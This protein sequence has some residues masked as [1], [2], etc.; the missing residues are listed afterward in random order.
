[1]LDGEASNF[2]NSKERKGGNAGWLYYQQ[3][4]DRHHFHHHHII[5]IITIIIII[6]KKKYAAR[7]GDVAS[8]TNN[9]QDFLR[10]IVNTLRLFIA[11]F[12]L[13]FYGFRTIICTSPFN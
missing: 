13:I 3:C 2:P 8:A 9:L 6:I 5:A 11:C 12:L 10:R 1:M 7:V 4:D